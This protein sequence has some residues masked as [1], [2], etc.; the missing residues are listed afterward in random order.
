[1]NQ[2]LTPSVR[3]KGDQIILKLG[4][5][6]TV[7]DVACVGSSRGDDVI[8]LINLLNSRRNEVLAKRDRDMLKELRK[9]PCHA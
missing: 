1:M 8:S 2:K 6:T 5:E 4:G 9:K 7:L 3:L